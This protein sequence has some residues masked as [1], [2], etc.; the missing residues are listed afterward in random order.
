MTSE[1]AMLSVDFD[2]ARFQVRAAAILRRDGHVLI[3][4]ATYETYWT[5]PGGRVELGESSV[6]ALEREILEEIKVAI[7]VGRL[8]YAVENFFTLDA[9][10]FHEFGFYFEAA[11]V[12]SFPF[13]AGGEV[14]FRS[15]DGSAD[16]EFAWVPDDETTLVDWNVKPPA[17]RTRLQHVDSGFEHLVL[18]ESYE[19]M[20]LFEG[21]DDGG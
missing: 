4:R 1:R 21:T 3:H 8:H 16:L 20:P 17:L 11:L 5:L 10:P 9:R 19:E 12:D 2:E 18:E 14:C 7:E 13:A 15:R 6:R